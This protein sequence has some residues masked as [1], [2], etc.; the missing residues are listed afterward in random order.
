[1]ISVGRNVVLQGKIC[2]YFADKLWLVETIT[3]PCFRNNQVFGTLSGVMHRLAC[4]L[5][6]SSTVFIDDASL[7]IADFQSKIILFLSICHGEFIK[8][9]EIIC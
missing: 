3:M 2:E 5:G 8:V 4:H 9:L 1:M 6:I 7:C